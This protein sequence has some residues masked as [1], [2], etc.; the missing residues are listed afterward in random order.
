MPTFHEPVADADE[1]QEA[2]RGL[3]H[4]TRSIKDPTGAYRVLGS[5]SWAMTSLRQTLDQLAAFYDGP[6]HTAATVNG[7]RPAGAEH[8]ARIAAELRDAAQH[9]RQ[10]G[11]HVDQAW[12]I[13][14]QV[15]YVPPPPAPVSA[16]ERARIAERIAKRLGPDDQFTRDSSRGDGQGREGLSL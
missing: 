11:G 12:T 14:G 8:A 2:L 13:D 6:A 3:A 16:T 1:A 15:A 9:V 5:L 4:A 7:D 10:V